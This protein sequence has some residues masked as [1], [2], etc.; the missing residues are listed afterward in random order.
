MKVEVT[1]LT[2]SLLKD[3]EARKQLAAAIADPSLTVTFMGKTYRLE[4]VR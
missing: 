3:H 2:R 1:K 4:S